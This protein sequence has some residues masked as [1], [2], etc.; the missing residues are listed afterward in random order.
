MPAW[1]R[2]WLL[3][4]LIGLLTSS[5]SGGGG[6]GWRDP[7]A[8]GSI[9]RNGGQEADGP[10]RVWTGADHLRRRSVRRWPGPCAPGS[11]ERAGGSRRRSGPGASSP[12]SRT[13][14]NVASPLCGESRKSRPN[15]ASTAE[16]NLTS[17]ERSARSQPPVVDESTRH[18]SSCSTSPSGALKRILTVSVSSEASGAVG[19]GVGLRRLGVLQRIDRGQVRRP[20]AGRDQLVE[21]RDGVPG[22][23]LAGVL[24][25]VV[26]V[27]GPR[28]AGSRSRSGGRRRPSPG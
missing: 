3:A 7:G 17:A 25:V 8:C 6:S 12:K 13:R 26:E 1:S 28:A 23:D 2:W 5:G 22:A 21:G 4:P 9:R 14:A 18:R 10:G 15:R 11:M 19:R 20:S 16:A 24:L 27:L